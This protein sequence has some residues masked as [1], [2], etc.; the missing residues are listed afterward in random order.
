MLKLF[1]ENADF[2]AAPEYG[3]DEADYRYLVPLTVVIGTLIA[4]ILPVEYFL[5]ILHFSVDSHPGL[6]V[7]TIHH[8]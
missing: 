8:V 3:P 6:S 1:L 4:C 7:R 5:K 2:F